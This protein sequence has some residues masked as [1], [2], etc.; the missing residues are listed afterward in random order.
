MSSNI[1]MQC[2]VSIDFLLRFKVRNLSPS[3]P[4][5]NIN[6]GPAAFPSI[7]IQTLFCLLHP[8]SCCHAHDSFHTGNEGTPFTRSIHHLTL[9]IVQLCCWLCSQIC[10]NCDIVDLHIFFPLFEE[11]LGVGTL[12]GHLELSVVQFYLS[13]SWLV[14]KCAGEMLQ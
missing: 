3:K 4:K 13:L 12:N 2:I 10:T 1:I 5:D 6:I 8:R 14:R 7:Q 11:C 9:M